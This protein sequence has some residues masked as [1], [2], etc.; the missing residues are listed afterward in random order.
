MNRKWL[1]L[2]APGAMLPYWVLAALGLYFLSSDIPLLG[3]IMEIVFRNNAL[4]LLGAL[5]GYCLIA[6]GCSIAFFVVVLRQKWDAL[7][8]AKTAVTVKLCQIPAYIL[9]FLLGVAF[10][11]S[12]FT[13]AVSLAL[14]VLDGL[15]L[16]LSGLLTVAAVIRADRQGIY[17]FG[18][19]AWVIALQFIFC[20]DVVAAIVF[21]KKLKNAK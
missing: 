5:L 19:H 8:L 9:I 16:L 17:S 21:Y 6:T 20:A 3:K 10:F 1:W 18:D 11:F 14:A 7:V 4:N 13:F 2:N 15:A 12:I